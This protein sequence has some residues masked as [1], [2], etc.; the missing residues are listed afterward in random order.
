MA[1]VD[2]ERRPA[3]RRGNPWPVGGGAGV[4]LQPGLGPAGGE[5]VPARADAARATPPPRDPRLADAAA[6][7][8]ARPRRSGLRLLLGLFLLIRR[9]WR[10]R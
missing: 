3:G 6:A 9:C 4:V 2:G 5:P 8:S 7:A 1:L 10:A